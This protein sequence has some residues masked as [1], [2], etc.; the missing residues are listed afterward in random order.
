MIA[1]TY[2]VAEKLILNALQLAQQ[3]HQELILEAESLQKTQQ[4]E[5]I[6][7]IATNKKQLVVQLEQFNTQLGQVLA[8]EKLPNDKQSLTEYFHRADAAGLESTASTAAWSQ[9]MQ[10]C[11]ECK[12]LN[13]ANG[14]SIDLLA[15]HTKRSLH[16]LKGKSELT[17]TYGPDGATR[18]ELYSQPLVSV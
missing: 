1:K 14:M 8:T 4:A 3:L 10:T 15:R 12:A 6:Q 2:P 7:T 18:S 11:S 5:L 13:D 16:I 17:N 9:L